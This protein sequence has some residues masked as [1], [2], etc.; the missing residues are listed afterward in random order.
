MSG[1]GKMKEGIKKGYS[2]GRDAANYVGKQLPKIPLSKS[3][4]YSKPS[5]TPP[6]PPSP[7]RLRHNPLIPPSPSA[8]MPEYLR[9]LLDKA[10]KPLATFKAAS[11]Y[12]IASPFSNIDG[13]YIL[14]NVDKVVEAASF[15][16]CF[17]I[18]ISRWFKYDPILGWLWRIF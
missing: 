1:L 15:F 4:N 7:P 9:K 6:A 5:D 13:G 10:H 14:K 12:H 18:T 16:F 17:K 2:I 8:T 11:F 3:D